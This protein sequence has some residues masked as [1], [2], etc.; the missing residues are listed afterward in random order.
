MS[1]VVL[2]NGNANAPV[3]R[4]YEKEI[5][6]IGLLSDGNVLVQLRS[7]IEKLSETGAVLQEYD[8]SDS[9]DGFLCIGSYL[10]MHGYQ[11]IDRIEYRG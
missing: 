5:K 6:D 9:Y 8:V 1:T 11:H 3:V 7:G 4:S 2:L 10:F